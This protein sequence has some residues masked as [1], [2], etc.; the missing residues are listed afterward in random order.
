MQ[1]DVLFLGGVKV[2]AHFNRF[3]LS[4]DQSKEDGGNET[5]PNSFML[6][7]SSIATCSGFY[8]LKFCQARNISANDISIKMQS[9][10]SK[11][12]KKLETIS[13][14]I[15]LFPNFPVKYK[16]AL[17]RAI[18]QCSVNKAIMNPPEILIDSY[19]GE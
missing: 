3:V 13:I 16:N 6:F 12:N 15:K 9:V 17:I 8:A 5:A 19:I 4:T 1:I 2:N 14:N 11:E 10:W 18:D 7:L